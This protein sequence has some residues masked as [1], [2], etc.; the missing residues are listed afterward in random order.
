MIRLPGVA[1][2]LSQINKGILTML[3]QSIRI[4][5]T[6]MIGLLAQ[7]ESARAQF[8]SEEGLSWSHPSREFQQSNQRGPRVPAL[9]TASNVRLSGQ[10][11]QVHS[12]HLQDRSGQEVKHTVARLFLED[13]RRLWIDFGENVNNR[14][15]ELRNGDYITV[16]GDRGRI[17]GRP[18]LMAEQYRIM[19][20]DMLVTRSESREGAGQSNAEQSVLLNGRVADA[21][22]VSLYE[23]DGPN[24]CLQ[25]GLQNG[26]TLLID[27]GIPS[28]PARLDIDQGD[29]IAV[30]GRRYYVKGQPVIQAEH[31][32]I[33]DQ[34]VRLRQA[35]EGRGDGLLS[36][37]P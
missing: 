3:K 1:L 23:P 13:G 14:H 21:Q 6:G 36:K 24:T 32:W 20:R 29:N 9:D 34:E 12:V 22:M 10:V 4:V 17:D 7:D 28:Y 18:V 19:G 26:R 35:G 30:R 31:L 33:N 5:L 15:A 37:M 8:A 16:R 27:L 25:L 11:N 2:S